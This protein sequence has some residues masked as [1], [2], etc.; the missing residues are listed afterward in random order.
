MSDGS[1]GSDDPNESPV[2]PRSPIGTWFWSVWATLTSP[3]LLVTVI[4]AGTMAGGA[5]IVVPDQYYAAASAVWILVSGSVGA[6]H[7]AAVYREGTERSILGVVRTAAGRFPAAVATYAIVFLAMV[8]SSVFVLALF[9]LFVRPFFLFPLVLGILLYLLIRTSF[10]IPAV[11]IDRYGPYRAITGGWNLT[12]Q[13]TW[14]I[15]GLYV[16]V[17]VFTVPAA[18]LRVTYESQ[19]ATVG[20]SALSGGLWAILGIC[21][22]R[23]YLELYFRPEPAGVADVPDWKRR[24]T[25][26]SQN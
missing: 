21:L 15:V 13:A 20:G 23:L 5:S 17:V 8:V 4:A 3:L 24:G 9:G 26:A 14:R 16:L 11:V 10:V 18:Y 12:R 2:P 19:L 7:V 25:P 22:A 1:G 6:A